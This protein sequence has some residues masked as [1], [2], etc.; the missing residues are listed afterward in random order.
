M[1]NNL[2]K[3]INKFLK[4]A[5]DIS[6]TYPSK[7]YTRSKVVYDL[8]KKS[9]LKL[10]EGHA[11]IGMSLAC[12]A[13]SEN[14]K[15]LEHAYSALEIFKDL[16]EPFGQVKAL[17]L[18]GISYFYN[19]VYEQALYYL[20]QA[21][22]LLETHQDNFLLSC[23]LNNIGEVFRESMKCDSALE[24][25]QRALKICMDTNSTINEA[26]IL[27][28]IGEIYF[29]LNKYKEALEY[30]TKSFDVLINEKEM[31][32]LG[33]VENKLGKIHYINK[34]YSKAS[35]YFTSALKRLD[36]IE[37]KFYAI[38][39][40]LNIA[41][42]EFLLDRSD[43]LC[44]FE[45]AIR[46]AEK[47]DAKKKLSEVYKTVAD[48]YEKTGEFEEALEYLKK[49]HRVEKEFTAAVVGN[50]FE[51][52]KI[53]LEHLNE[54]SKFDEVE[55][56][57]RRLEME[58]SNQKNELEKMQELNEVLEVKAFEDELTCVPNRRYINNHINKTWEEVLSKDQIIALFIIDID[59]FKIYNDSWGHPE[60]DKCLLKVANCLKELQVTRND[61][62]G[63]YGGEEFIYYAKNISY[64]QALELGNLF[65][66]EV[67]KLSLKYTIDNKSS[68]LTISVGGVL[69]K[70][71]N[72]KNIS[73]MIQ[74][75]DKELYK[76][77][78]MG[79][80]I[81]SLNNLNEINKGI[82]K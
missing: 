30:F 54:N 44:N 73:S 32:N 48:H 29:L 79:R 46:Y 36:G 56:I 74:Y 15:M 58:I 70:L 53:E 25:Y 16:Q 4:E 45:K 64:D 65:R 69:G 19:A 68:V 59:H 13:K 2:Q 17:N 35:E 78:N 43:P 50:K 51:I 52:L 33:E 55:M 18:I 61:I 12:R 38:D 6:T 47:T 39:V 3:E 1:D 76:A 7:S 75:A 80:N 27:G 34:D 66:V 63:R 81:T 49:Y 82:P 77:K 5:K 62:F 10:E 9:N 31:V 22:D 60:G 71:T 23:V 11:L 67:E 28:N 40:L 57:N 14:N 24:Y 42:L 20:M 72:F 41:K 21:L 37:N 8:S 26:S